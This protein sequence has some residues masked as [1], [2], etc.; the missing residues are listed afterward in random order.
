M[1]LS[2]D[3]HILFCPLVQ[4]PFSPSIYKWWWSWSHYLLLRF[5]CWPYCYMLSTLRHFKRHDW[6]FDDHLPIQNINAFDLVTM[7]ACPIS[8]QSKAQQESKTTYNRLISCHIWMNTEPINSRWYMFF[9]LS[10]SPSTKLFRLLVGNLHAW[11]L[12]NWAW[13]SCLSLPSSFYSYIILVVDTFQWGSTWSKEK[14]LL[15]PPTIRCT[16]HRA[17]SW[18]SFPVLLEY[19]MRVLN[20]A[21]PC[22]VSLTFLKVKGPYVVIHA[23]IIFPLAK[24]Y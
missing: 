1:N 22:F 11:Y 14:A 13:A 8:R 2:Q 17:S 7:F 16:V 24:L 9:H 4:F 10:L 20:A 3:M 5:I 19:M 21:Y 6:H 15:Y 23:H 12:S 18:C